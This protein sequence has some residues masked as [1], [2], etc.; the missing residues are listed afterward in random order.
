[1]EQGLEARRHIRSYWADITDRRPLDRLYVNA[2]GSVELEQGRE[3][4]NENDYGHA[5]VNEQ[6]PEADSFTTIADDVPPST[7]PASPLDQE[8]RD[9]RNL[10]E[11]LAQRGDV[12]DDF[13]ASVGLT[14]SFADGV[15]RVQERGRF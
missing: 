10:L 14:R 4:E 5:H 6:E 15:E 9:A 7:S 11:R 13:W 3:N 12:G 1:M 2:N 8:L